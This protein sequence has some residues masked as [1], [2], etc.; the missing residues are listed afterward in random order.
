MS[1]VRVN[2]LS[3]E[4]STGGPTISGITTFSSTNYFVPPS[5]DTG[6][7]PQSCASG[8][9]RFNTDTASL[10][11]FRGNT[12]GWVQLE[13]E[14]ASPIGARALFG[15]GSGN[16]ATVFTIDYT[17]VATLGNALDFGDLATAQDATGGAANNVRGII[18]GGYTP[19]PAGDSDVIQRV[20]I[21]TAGDAVDFGDQVT[22]ARNAGATSTAHGGL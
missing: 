18:A 4:N 7:R 21:A 2:N 11:Y 13:A 16:P 8:S 19:S 22:T 14:E 17:Q 20:T 3:T 15:G 10:E 9:L 1:E 6:S 12:V 5:G